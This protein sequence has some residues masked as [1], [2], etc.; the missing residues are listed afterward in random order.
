MP[1][2]RVFSFDAGLISSSSLIFFVD[3]CLHF[4]MCCIFVVQT[5]LVL[6]GGVILFLP[7]ASPP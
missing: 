7:T 3:I 1:A 2:V 6:A 4:L 5:Y